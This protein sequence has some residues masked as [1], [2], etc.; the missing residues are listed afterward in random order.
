MTKEITNKYMFV[1]GERFG[2]M[3]VVDILVKEGIKIPSKVHKYL[4]DVH[5][6]GLKAEG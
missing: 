1:M 2:A 4:N 6:K 3:N 5:K